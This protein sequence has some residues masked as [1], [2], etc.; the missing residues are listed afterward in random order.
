MKL[1]ST[2]RGRTGVRQRTD[3][4]ANVD[5]HPVRRSLE[6]MR[7]GGICPNRSPLM[8]FEQEIAS[9]RQRIARAEHARDRTRASGNQEL[10]LQACSTISALD[11]Q[12]DLLRQKRHQDADRLPGPNA[13]S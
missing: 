12:L 1:R 2:R 11:M 8:T 4:I 7:P 9:L 6:A 5:E 10:Y 13:C 3:S